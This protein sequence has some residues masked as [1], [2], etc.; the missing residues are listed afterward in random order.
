MSY[1]KLRCHDVCS[2]SDQIT[3]KKI[4]GHVSVEV[5][6][7]CRESNIKLALWAHSS[8]C[9]T[10]RVQNEYLDLVLSD[11]LIV[12]VFYITQQVLLNQFHCSTLTNLT[13][14]FWCHSTHIVE[15]KYSV[16]VSLLYRCIPTYHD[17]AKL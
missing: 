9:F 10:E 14:S 8:H 12:V 13:K 6:K 15:Y 1:I 5:W 17:N 7:S 11:N 2:A 3:E 16:C 4:I